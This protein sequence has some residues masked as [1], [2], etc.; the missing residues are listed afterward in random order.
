MTISAR[1][2]VPISAIGMLT[3]GLVQEDLNPDRV[4]LLDEG[5]ILRDQNAPQ[6]RDHRR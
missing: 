6:G 3:S 4:H 1:M 5:R 2:I